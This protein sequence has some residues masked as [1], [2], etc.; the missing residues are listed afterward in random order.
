[1]GRAAPIVGLTFA[2]VSGVALSLAGAPFG[3]APLLFIFWAL[4]PVRTSTGPATARILSVVSVAGFLAG[5]AGDHTGGS[6][7][8][9]APGSVA[10]L[11]GRFLATP[12]SGSAPFEPSNGCG[13]TTV[14]VPSA[15]SRTEAGRAL[16]LHGMWR[17]GSH[18]PWFQ[19][20]RIEQD[21]SSQSGRMSTLRWRGVRWRD[22]LVDRLER[23]YGPRAPLVNALTLARREGLDPAVRE[24]FASTGIAHLLAIS[25]F[26][27]GVIAGIALVL[28]RRLGMSR[29]MAGL[30]SAGLAWAYVTIIGFPDAACRAALILALV[31]VSRARGR[32]PSRWGALAVAALVLLVMDPSR[33]TSPGFQL[34]FAG[35]AGLV[36]GSRRAAEALRCVPGLRSWA[37]A[38]TAVAA[39][40]AATLATL[41]IV[42]WHF[43]RVSLVGIPMTLVATPLVSIA[44]PGALASIAAD[45]LSPTLASFLAGGVSLLLDILVGLSGIVAGIPGANAWTSKG[46]VVGGVLGASIAI[47]LARRPGIGALGR[48]GLILLYASLGVLTWPLILGL[49]DR[50]TL[51]IYVI[52]VGQGDGIAVRTPAG[53]WLLVDAG[54]PASGMLS[55][56][57]DTEED[58]QRHPVVR[59]LRGRGVLRL[60]RMILSHPDLDHIGG[61]RA[62][63]STFPVGQVLDPA[64][65]VGKSSYADLLASAESRGVPWFAARAGD[66]FDVDGVTFS[67]LHPREELDEELDEGLDSGTDANDAS[68]VVLVS[69]RGFRALL[70]G[71]A[72]AD[73][74]KG[75]A[76]EVGDIDVLK[77]GHHGSDTSSDSSFLATIRPEVALISVGRRN[78]YGH[79]SPR[80]VNRLEGVGATVYRTD[81]SGAVRVIVRRDGSYVVRPEQTP[82]VSGGTPRWP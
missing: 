47:V 32:P 49:Q 55:G 27:V 59:A 18:R 52:D 15:Q 54:P 39:G 79:P 82:A 81:R 63:L 25:G 21:R 69:W 17:E 41:P 58:P 80:V 40:M 31:A 44:L 72:Y 26:H 8:T 77:V 60:E 22:S 57:S 6:C 36:G 43:D 11:T 35:A 73:V 28:L 70:T 62:V 12:R 42:A 37:T 48:R 3:M 66:R 53:R 33:L 75:I 4:P 5:W 9:S 45:L 1:L 29:R 19:V 51:E 64:L 56:Q 46:T 14:V 23:L 10:V 65:P 13:V 68:V 30:G 2:F 76:N 71:D 7:V 34:S 61:A 78:R 24:I 20:R 38:R 50:G 67:I 16:I 74:E